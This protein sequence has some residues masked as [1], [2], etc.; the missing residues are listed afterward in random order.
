ML[1]IATAISKL[2]Y[3][4]ATVVN[5][6]IIT[7]EN[8]VLHTIR[9]NFDNVVNSA[10]VIPSNLFYNL[11]ACIVC[12]CFCS[13]YTLQS[14]WSYACV[15]HVNTLAE[16]LL[17]NVDWMSAPHYVYAANRVDTILYASQ[18]IYYICS[19][20][21]HIAY[22]RSIESTNVVYSL[23]CF[24]QQLPTQTNHSHWAHSKNSRK[25]TYSHT[26][27]NHVVIAG[28]LAIRIS[29]RRSARQFAP[30]RLN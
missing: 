30:C 18:P 10:T 3:D 2:T 12:N 23:G 26:N 8:G 13:F 19:I 7:N 14:I 1:L 20:P 5:K 25:Y 15:L 17:W 21:M 11:C 9:G 16:R 22:V 29:G 28:K 4:P 6:A 27:L 24:L